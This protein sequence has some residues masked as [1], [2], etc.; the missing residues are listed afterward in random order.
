MILKDIIKVSYKALR[1]QRLRSVLTILGISIGI[2]IV[3][4]IMSAGRGLDKF[5]LSQMEIFGSDTVWI[6]VKI[7]S[8]KKTSTENAS[9]QA[10]GITITTMKEKDIDSIRK[11]PNIS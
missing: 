7:P 5:L 8:T 9:G 2:A 3:I 1:A 4:T 10:T 6:E 11:H